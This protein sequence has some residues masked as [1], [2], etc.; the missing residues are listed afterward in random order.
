MK[1]HVNINQYFSNTFPTNARNSYTSIIKKH[2]LKRKKFRQRNLFE[3][4]C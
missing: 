3:S 2:V 1:E 4:A